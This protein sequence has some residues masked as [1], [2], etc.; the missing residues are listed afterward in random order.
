[1]SDSDEYDLQGAVERLAEIKKQQDELEM[2]YALLR[3]EIVP[4]LEQAQFFIDPETG[5]KKVAYRVAPERTVVDADLLA[6]YVPEDVLNEVT[7]R[8]IKTDA[9]WQANKAGRIPDE[10]AARVVKLVP[11]TPHVRF[12]DPTDLAHRAAP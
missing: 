1:M 7:V 4:L 8:K 10:V 12:G 9:F 5:E 6:S 3:D 2:E 11:Q